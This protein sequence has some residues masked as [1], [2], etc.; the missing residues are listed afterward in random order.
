LLLMT[1]HFPLNPGTFGPKTIPG[2]HF[3]VWRLTRM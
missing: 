2:A 1:H 3:R